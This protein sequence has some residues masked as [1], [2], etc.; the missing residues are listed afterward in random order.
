MSLVEGELGISS[1]STSVSVRSEVGLEVGLDYEAAARKMTVH[2]IQVRGVPHKDMGGANN[3]QV[4]SYYT[5]TCY[6]SIA[7]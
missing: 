1:R 2:V 4:N 3:T 7:Y 5:Y 6:G